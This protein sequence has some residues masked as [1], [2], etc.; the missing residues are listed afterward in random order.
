M[1]LP[2]SFIILLYYQLFSLYQTLIEQV[3]IRK[4]YLFISKI[5]FKIKKIQLMGG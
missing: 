4:R 5:L 2:C 3:K 1:I